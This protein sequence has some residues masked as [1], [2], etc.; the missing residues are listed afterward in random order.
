MFGEMGVA[1]DELVY[2][3]RVPRRDQNVV[4]LS[5]FDRAVISQRA[6]SVADSLVSLELLVR[7]IE[8]QNL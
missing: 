6:L 2:V 8:E 5:G 3:I 7:R 4:Q 1:R